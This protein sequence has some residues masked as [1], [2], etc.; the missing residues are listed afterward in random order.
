MKV[1]IYVETPSGKTITLTVEP[2]DGIED[3]KVKIQEKEGILLDQQ[4]LMFRARQLVNGHTLWYYNIQR[5]ST[6]CVELRVSGSIQIF[7][8][9]ICGTTISVEVDPSDS[10]ETV[11]AIIQEKN[12]I[13]PYQ[14]W[15]Y[16]YCSKLQ[17]GRI[18]SDYNIRNECTLIMV[19]HSGLT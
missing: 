15:L 14:Q 16:L 3:V 9:Y 6:L 17:D 18:L 4:R 19:L 11:K 5:E 7:I 2:L 12:G 10:I 1:Q 13:P 8:E